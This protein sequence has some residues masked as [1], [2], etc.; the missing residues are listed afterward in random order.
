MA[1]ACNARD[2]LAAVEANDLL[3][4]AYAFERQKRNEHEPCRT[5]HILSTPRRGGVPILSGWRPDPVR[6]VRRYAR[7]AQPAAFDL[8]DGHWR[9]A[10]VLR[11]Y[12]DHA[13]P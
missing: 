5:H 6:L 12:P 2:E 10:G 1:V 3:R 4:S 9:D 8:A 11:R 13:W 7:P